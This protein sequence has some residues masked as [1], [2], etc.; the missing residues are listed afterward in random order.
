M[1]KGKNLI[2]HANSFYWKFSLENEIT[3]FQINT[4]SSILR[5]SAEGSLLGCGSII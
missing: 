5:C 3:V 1:L 4:E 2:A